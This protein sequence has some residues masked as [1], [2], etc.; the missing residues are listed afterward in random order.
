M[1]GN[2][3]GN[4][5][6]R[7]PDN[8]HN[9][10]NMDE[11]VQHPSG[12]DNGTTAEFKSGERRPVTDSGDNKLGRQGGGPGEHQSKAGEQGY[13]SENNYHTIK[14]GDHTSSGEIRG[15]GSLK[16]GSSADQDMKYGYTNADYSDEIKQTR[17]NRQDSG[18]GAVTG[19]ANREGG[20]KDGRG[21]GKSSGHEGKNN[22]NNDVR[23][24]KKND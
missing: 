18:P 2:H 6:H 9:R 8:I 4:S 19:S 1:K 23:V 5:D 3:K 16:D 21:G 24:N 17:W 14:K 12:D 10:H 15:A 7:S 20:D 13:K 22:P 11:A